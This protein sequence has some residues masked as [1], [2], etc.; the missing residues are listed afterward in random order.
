METRGTENEIPTSP[1]RPPPPW[2]EL[3]GDVTANILQRL[4]TEEILE[5]AQKVCSTWWKVCKD[6]AIWRVV[7]LNK[8]SEDCRD[9]DLMCRCAVDRSQGQLTDLSIFWFGD[10]ELLNNVARRYKCFT[11]CHI[12]I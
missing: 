10:D 12:L 4:G 1:P 6:P 2:I 9:F 7:H 8:P 5:N 3:P 11:F